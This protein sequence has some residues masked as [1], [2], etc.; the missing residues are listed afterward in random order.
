MMRNLLH[1]IFY[2]G[3]V[4]V[5]IKATA[6]AP[7]SN[8]NPCNAT[9]L[10]PYLPTSTSS[11]A[12]ASGTVNMATNSSTTLPMAGITS[13][14]GTEDDDV[15][16]TFVATNPVM[17]LNLSSITGSTTDLEA[18]LYTGT[19]SNLTNYA[20][21]GLSGLPWEMDGGTGTVYLTPGTTYFLQIYS[22]SS[23]AQTTSFN[24]CLYGPEPA[25][26]A[27]T[28]APPGTAGD[29]CSTAPTMT[30]NGD[31]GG[32]TGSYGASNGDPNI[33]DG[34]TTCGID[35]NTSW[36]SFIASSTTASFYLYTIGPL[37]NAS[38]STCTGGLEVQFF[39][40]ETCSSLSY[41]NNVSWNGLD[42]DGNVAT[43]SGSNC[44][45]SSAAFGGGSVQRVTLSSLM[46]GAK[47]YIKID[48]YDGDVCDYAFRPESGLLP[49]TYLFFK[50]SNNGKTNMLNWTTASEQNNDGF[51]VEYSRDGIHFSSLGFVNGAGNATSENSYQFIHERPSEG[52]NYYRLKQVDFDGKVEYS[53]I[54]KI[55]NGKDGKPGLRIDSQSEAELSYSLYGSDLPP[56]AL[57]V[58]DNLGR[59]MLAITDNISTSGTLDI[60][61][62]ALGIYYLRAVNWDGSVSVTKWIKQ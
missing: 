18:A 62:L 14:T 26:Q 40:G 3:S 21:D 13:C 53:A 37:E 47:Y 56:A 30:L 57:G 28:G 19:C 32:N 17:T 45:N 35:N 33:P 9:V 38:G 39:K 42:N 7:P 41:H 61:S 58:F 4:F 54:L 1:F 60:S 27:P 51:D 49:V 25:Y 31:Y 12:G 36:L 22:W 43:A 23:S 8:D 44:I 52:V 16:Y 24:I 59:T 6:I 11:C 34:A 5:S 55:N 48:G 29:W 10:T 50:G 15:W 2:V 46:S 20:C